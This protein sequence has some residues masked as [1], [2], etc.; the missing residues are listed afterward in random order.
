M[1]HSVVGFLDRILL[2]FFIA[3]PPGI[4]TSWD[5]ARLLRSETYDNRLGPEQDSSSVPFLIGD[6][7]MQVVSQREQHPVGKRMLVLPVAKIEKSSVRFI[8]W[9]FR[10]FVQ[11]A[12]E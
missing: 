2:P 12:M 7:Q 3:L 6:R 4:R 10:V 11:D 8:V 1:A 9:S 5:L